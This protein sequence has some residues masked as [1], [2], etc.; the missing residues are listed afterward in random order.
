M[1]DSKSAFLYASYENVAK[2]DPI[3]IY[4]TSKFSS[5]SEPN[6]LGLHGIH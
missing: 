1:K 2:G 4:T 3:A 5:F 6:E